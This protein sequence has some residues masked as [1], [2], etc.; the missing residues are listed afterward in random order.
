MFTQQEDTRS[1]GVHI[2]FKNNYFDCSPDT[3]L[4]RSSQAIPVGTGLN[5]EIVNNTFSRFRSIITGGS[6]AD[7][8]VAAAS[9]TVFTKLVNNFIASGNITRGNTAESDVWGIIWMSGNVMRGSQPTSFP[10]TKHYS[11]GNTFLANITTSGSGALYYPVEGSAIDYDTGVDYSIQP[12]QDAWGPSEG[13]RWIGSAARPRYD[14]TEFPTS[15][16]TY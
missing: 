14:Q 7:L 4:V 8:A 6:S 16:V 9:N 10:G 12:T 11:A 13:S 1:T 3:D 2:I 5:L 15:V